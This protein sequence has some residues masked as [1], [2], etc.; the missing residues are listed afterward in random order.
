MTL[1]LLAL[2]GCASDP[3]YKTGQNWVAEQEQER[4]M[5]QAQGFPQYSCD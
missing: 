5:L 4:R 2:A 3:R 1:A